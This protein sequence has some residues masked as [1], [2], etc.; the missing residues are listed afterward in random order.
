MRS[1]EPPALPTAAPGPRT[2]SKARTAEAA[3][4]TSWT[5]PDLRIAARPSTGGDT[6]PDAEYER[7][8]ADG[9]SAGIARGEERLQAAESLLQHAA[10]ALN[11]SKA[12]LVQDL[13]R[14]LHALALAVARR[15]VMHEL[16][17]DPELTAKLVRRALELVDPE[18]ALAIRVHPQ[19]LEALK[20]PIAI[21]AGGEGI[22]E[23]RWIADPD[24]DR[25]SFLL[26]GPQRIVDGRLDTALRSLYERL[27]HD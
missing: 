12:P 1:W 2:P 15:L 14:N 4:A 6:D 24:L 22:V 8:Y 9:M 10:E 20:E 7:G 5:L 25:G 23:L 26:E 11:A 19:D 21:A 17:A 18:A 3:P 13:E 27:D 16:E